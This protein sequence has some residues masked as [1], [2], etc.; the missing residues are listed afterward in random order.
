MRSNIIIAGGLI[1]FIVIMTTQRPFKANDKSSIVH[2]GIVT[3]MYETSFKDF[4]VKLKDHAETYYIDGGINN[5]FSLSELKSMIMYKPV[6]IQYPDR[7]NPL[8][9]EDKKYYISKLEY[10]GQIIFAED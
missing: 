2:R 8:H 3:E 10:D 5:G 1:L 7:W 9:D 6:T 4:V